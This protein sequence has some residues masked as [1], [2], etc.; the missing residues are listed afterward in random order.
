MPDV[1]ADRRQTPRYSLVVMAEVTVLS[2]GDKLTTRTSDIS[3]T[4]CYLDTLNPVSKGQQVHVRLV[5]KGQSFEADATVMYVSRGLG[6]GIKFQ[7]NL[8]PEHV[9]VLERWLEEAATKT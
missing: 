4:G 3:R 6:M 8:L 1:M 7:D 5:Q 2:S 9:A